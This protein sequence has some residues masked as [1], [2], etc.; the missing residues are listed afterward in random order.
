MDILIRM[1]MIVPGEN[2]SEIKQSVMVRP[3]EGP[4]MSRMMAGFY[5]L[6]WHQSM[7]PARS[8][9]LLEVPQFGTF[10]SQQGVGWTR[11]GW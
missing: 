3:P 8:V 6:G 2:K 7:Q 9:E 11:G 4:K 1:E 10:R 5:T